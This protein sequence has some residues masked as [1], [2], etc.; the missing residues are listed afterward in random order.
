M[1][2]FDNIDDDEYDGDLEDDDYEDPLVDLIIEKQDNQV[3][4][5]NQAGRNNLNLE[6]SR[7][8][9]DKVFKKEFS[10]EG[11]KAVFI[12]E[13]EEETVENNST[14][15]KEKLVSIQESTNKKNSLKTSKNSK[16]S[17]PVLIVSKTKEKLEKISPNASPK[18]PQTDLYSSLRRNKQNDIYSQEPSE[19]ALSSSMKQ[20]SNHSIGHLQETILQL[21]KQLRDEK[22][23]NQNVKDRKSV[24]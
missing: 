23:R 3:T 11:L 4:Q 7:R 1:T 15:N 17:S 10:K 20:T 24:V 14:A 12:E 18:K 21:N 8:I 13:T 2:L 19:L 5:N 6:S 22:N 16:L 9:S